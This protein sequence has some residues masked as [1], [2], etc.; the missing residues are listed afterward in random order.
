MTACDVILKILT[1]GAPRSCV[2]AA[3]A[4]L[5]GFKQSLWAAYGI[6]GR[7]LTAVIT[8]AGRELRGGLPHVEGEALGRGLGPWAGVA[9]EPIIAA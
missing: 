3:R 7:P 5:L 6:A 9:F 1:I 4:Y 8:E 2:D